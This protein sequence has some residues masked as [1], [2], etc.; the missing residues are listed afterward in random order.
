MK[1]FALFILFIE[2]T[3]VHG[4][5]RLLTK[6]V[7]M[8]TEWKLN[9]HKNYSNT[10]E[11]HKAMLKWL[12]NK[13]DIDEQ[14]LKYENGESTYKRG[15][16][17]YS[18]FSNEEKRQS[19]M[20]VAVPPEENPDDIRRLLFLTSPVQ[21]PAIN[22]VTL[23]RVGPVDDQESCNSCWAFS[24]AGVIEGVLRK[25]NIR[26]SV[27]P[28]QLVDCSTKFCWGCNSGWSK[29]ALDYVKSQGIS[30]ES[31]YPYK[32]VTQNCTYNKK[33]A[34]GYISRVFEVATRGKKLKCQKSNF[35]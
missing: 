29:Y 9:F 32:A 8:F 5:H 10:L 30:K 18:D 25:R 2:A 6:D 31:S 17:K 28:Q 26:D 13:A 33:N 11:E 34:L 19:L 16:S 27:S 23:G 15:L 24:A 4:S 7:R 14:N 12:K 21:L 3:C 1:L 35:Q 22:W 20:G